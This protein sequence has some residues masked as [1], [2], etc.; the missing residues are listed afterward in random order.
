MT[1]KNRLSWRLAVGVSAI[2]SILAGGF[3]FGARPASSASPVEMSPAA[4]TPPAAFGAKTRAVQ[5]MGER[6]LSFEENRGQTERTVRFLSRGDGYSLFL[7]PP[8]AVLAWNAPPVATVLRLQLVGANPGA[9]VQGEEPLPGKTHYFVGNNPAG[10]VVD[11]PSYAKIRY[12]NVYPGIDVVYYGN[13]R[14]LE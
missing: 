8:E 9:K 3:G 13:Q 7:M 11:V 1:C 4:L 6:P 12:R 2:G 10:W 5:T 14:R